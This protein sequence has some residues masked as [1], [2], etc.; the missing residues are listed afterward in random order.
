MS[1]ASDAP[2]RFWQGLARQLVLGM[3]VLLAVGCSKND[4]GSNNIEALSKLFDSKFTDVSGKNYDFSALRGKTLVVNFWATW[5]PPCIEE[6]PLFNEMQN[7]WK[8]KGVVFVGI[9]TD[10]ADK[11]RS[12]IIKS[13]VNYPMLIGGQPGFELSRELGNRHGGI[14]FTVIIDAQGHI[15]KRHMGLYSGKELGADLARVVP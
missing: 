1:F 6:I 9:A 12:F 5:C 2:P 4:P 13:P 7:R 15:V 14:P 3:M 11:V 8:G 10:Q